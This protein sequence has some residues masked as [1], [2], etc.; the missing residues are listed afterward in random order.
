M[1]ITEHSG[2]EIE[3]GTMLDAI[4]AALMALGSAAANI[5]GTTLQA[6]NRT[7]SSIAVAIVVSEEFVGKMGP[8]ITEYN[9]EPSNRLIQEF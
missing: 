9:P 4:V 1:P 6:T 7:T 2:P 8:M 3:A 5:I